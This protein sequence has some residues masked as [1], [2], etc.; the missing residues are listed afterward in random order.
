M[1]KEPKHKL[2]VGLMLHGAAEKVCSDNILTAS[3]VL[4][5]EPSLFLRTAFN[6]PEPVGLRQVLK[7]LAL[8]IWPIILF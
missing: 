6:W 2:A 7:R 5:L 4:T 3:N 1:I 8:E